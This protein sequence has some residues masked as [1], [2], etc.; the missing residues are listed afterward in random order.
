MLRSTTVVPRAEM[1]GRKKAGTITLDRQSRFRRRIL[2]ATDDGREL[3]LDLAEPTYLADGDGLAL[4]D[5]SV[6][7]VKAA[8][9]DLMEIHAHSVLELARIAWHLGN[10]HTPAEVTD[11]AIY[12]QPDHVLA[13]MVAG[14]GAHI[15]LVKRPF[16]PEGGAYGGQRPIDEPGHHHHGHHH[17][18]HD[19][20]HDHDHPPKARGNPRSR[21]P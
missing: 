9:E 16:E 5:G 10:R 13:E 6:V 7:T 21:R 3:M 4:E 1:R 14:L 18:G 20:A 15:H 8:A 2:L 17:H 11:H 12:I 19:H